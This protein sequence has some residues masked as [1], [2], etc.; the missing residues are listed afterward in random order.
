MEKNIWEGS[1]LKCKK[2]KDLLKHLKIDVCSD[3]F[4]PLPFPPGHED[5]LKENYIKEQEGA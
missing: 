5:W 2:E 4:G 3:C 1:C